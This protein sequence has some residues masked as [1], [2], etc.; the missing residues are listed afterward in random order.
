MSSDWADFCDDMGFGDGAESFDNFERW[1]NSCADYC[2]ND[3]DQWSYY[4]PNESVEELQDEDD[5]SDSDDD[6]G[7]DADA[8]I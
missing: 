2:Y 8:G 5:S 4:N 7:Y 1:L 6:L 3:D